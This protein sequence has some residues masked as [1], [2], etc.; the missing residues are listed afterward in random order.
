[1]DVSRLIEPAGLVLGQ[2]AYAAVAAGHAHW[3]AGGPAAFTLARLIDGDEA[4]LVRADDIPPDWLSILARVTAPL[5][6]ADL[7][8]GPLVM[9]ILN[10]TPDSFSD[11]GRH[12]GPEDAIRAGIAMAAGGAGLLDIGGESTRPGSA[13]V[14]HE[15][16]WARI[17]PVVAGLRA[18]IDNARTDVALS[19]DT[20]NAR[21]MSA[22]LRQGATLINDVSALMHDP[23]ALTV[24]AQAGCPVVLMHM[25]GSPQTMQHL[26]TYGDVGVEVTREL[27]ARIDAAVA[28]GIARARIIVD[29]GIGFAKTGAQNAALLG[30]LPILANLG[31]RV[32]LGTSRKRVLGELAG[33]TMAG[34]RD[35]GTLVSSLPG[36]ELGNTILRV[37][38]VPMMVQALRVWQGMWTC[39]KRLS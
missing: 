3:L 29:P 27:A 15:E 18:R 22:A 16:E 30:R 35:P 34:D 37:H 28:A 14:T 26:A 6:S 12:F 21:T 8:D 31:C 13:V 19:I 23:S 33:V 1:M 38:N 24:V 32:L 11:G 10:V 17:G 36:L 5:P 2:G 4:R 7:P 25:R 20:R 39:D 9:G